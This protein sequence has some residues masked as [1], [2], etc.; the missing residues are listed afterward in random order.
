MCKYVRVTK[1][2]LKHMNLG[3]LKL[4]QEN[5]WG[6]KMQFFITNIIFNKC[7]FIE[8]KNFLLHFRK[9]KNVSLIWYYCFISG[10]T[11]FHYHL[12]SIYTFCIYRIYVSTSVVLVCMYL[13]IFQVIENKWPDSSTFDK[14]I[15]SGSIW[16]QWKVIFQRGKRKRESM[17]KMRNDEVFPQ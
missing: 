15:T 12:P 4:E 11:K 6:K 3:F 10:M 17:S 14:T 7:I 8:N 13:V 2:V 5:I 1:I 9:P 16:Q